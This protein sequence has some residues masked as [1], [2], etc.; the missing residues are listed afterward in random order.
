MYERVELYDHALVNLPLAGCNFSASSLGHFTPGETHS[1]AT[2]I[3]HCFP[4]VRS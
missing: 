2:S 4:P 1:D 3:G